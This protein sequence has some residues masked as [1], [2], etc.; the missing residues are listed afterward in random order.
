ML[1]RF[2][3]SLSER[4]DLGKDRAVLYLAKLALRS[5]REIENLGNVG[6][7]R[8]ILPLALALSRGVFDLDLGAEGEG[9]GKDEL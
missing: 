2:A 1:R 4:P 6:G 3:C 5:V 8:T 9:G 7:Q